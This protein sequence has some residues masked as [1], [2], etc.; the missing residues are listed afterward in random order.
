[1]LQLKRFFLINLVIVCGV[2][3]P[4]GRYLILGEL[5]LLPCTRTVSKRSYVDSGTFDPSLML[6]GQ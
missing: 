1:M 6:P 4:W 3:A 5:H 2:I